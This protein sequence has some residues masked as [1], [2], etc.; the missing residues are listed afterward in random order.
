MDH[1]Q[2]HLNFPDPII[3]F[4]RVVGSTELWRVQPVK[5][6]NPVVVLGNVWPEVKVAIIALSGQGIRQ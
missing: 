6:C 5:I 4:N 2:L 3:R 1:F